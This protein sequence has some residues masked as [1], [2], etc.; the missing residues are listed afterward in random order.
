MAR[1]E[2]WER[3][4]DEAE[5]LASSSRDIVAYANDATEKIKDL[6]SIVD[7]LE[8]AN[9]TQES[10]IEDMQATIDTLNE[11]LNWYRS[12]PDYRGAKLAK[13]VGI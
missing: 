9:K 2:D 7:E 8:K 12:L 6:S 5:S 4:S 10:D 11:E 13:D 1:K 3:L